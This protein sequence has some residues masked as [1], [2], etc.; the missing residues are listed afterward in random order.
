MIK[1]IIG[2][3]EEQQ[4]SLA[5]QKTHTETP[6]SLLVKKESFLKRLF[7][8]KRLNYRSLMQNI[9]SF[10]GL[11]CKR[12]LQ[13]YEKLLVKRLLLVKRAAVCV[14]VYVSF[15]KKPYKKDD[16]WHLSEEI[17]F[18]EATPRR[19]PSMLKPLGF[20]K[21]SQSLQQSRQKILCSEYRLFSKALLQKRHIILRE[22]SCHLVREHETLYD[23]YET[24]DI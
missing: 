19:D 15:T 10:I 22:T 6:H 16:I 7:L 24:F 23:S 1:H 18:C 14:C 2:C 8:V 4:S 17:T 9:V 21:S 13:F 11:F 5:L 12:D 20:R 3:S